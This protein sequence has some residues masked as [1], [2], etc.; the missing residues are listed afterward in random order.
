MG[1][2]GDPNN[3]TRVFC[4]RDRLFQEAMDAEYAADETRRKWRIWILTTAICLIAGS[5]LGMMIWMH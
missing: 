5:V 3:E 2:S 1:T 4:Q